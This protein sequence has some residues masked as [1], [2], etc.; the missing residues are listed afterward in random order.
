[1]LFRLAHAECTENYVAAK[2]S[3]GC[4]L[5]VVAGAPAQTA[6]LAELEVSSIFT[7]VFVRH[8]APRD[9]NGNDET[10]NKL[11]QQMQQ[12]QDL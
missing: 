11:M 3:N 4:C 12:M 5:Q 7:L 1:M 6:Q 8:N 10:I 2:P 9:A